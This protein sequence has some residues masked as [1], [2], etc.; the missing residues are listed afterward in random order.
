MDFPDV[1][2]I[3]SLDKEPFHSAY[4]LAEVLKVSH[5]TV[6]D[7]LHDSLGMRNLH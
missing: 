1:K 5:S 3:A 4:S 7:R 2:L 6:L